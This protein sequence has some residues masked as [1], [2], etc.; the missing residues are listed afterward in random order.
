MLRGSLVVLLVAALTRDMTR[1]APS[2]TIIA[3]QSSLTTTS[4]TS[5]TR[6]TVPTKSNQ[7][8]QD[9]PSI[10][11]A[12]PQRLLDDKVT[13]QQQ[14][15]Q[16]EETTETVCVIPPGMRLATVRDPQ[17]NPLFDMVVVD[18]D[19]MGQHIATKGFWE[20]RQVQDVED[21]A[22]P[23]VINNNN[24]TSS[25][26]AANVAGGGAVFYDVGANIGYY[27]FLFAHAG[28][29]VVAF[30]PLPQNVAAYRATLCLHPEWATRITLVEQGLSDRTATCQLIGTTLASKAQ[31]LNGVVEV[32][33]P[34]ASSTEQP[35]PV[36]TPCAEQPGLAIC[37]TTVV[38]TLDAAVL[39][40]PNDGNAQARFPPPSIIKM[41]V[42]G[43]ELQ[44]LQ[45]ATELFRRTPPEL[46]QF[47]FKSA[48]Q[49]QVSDWLAAHGYE[50]GTKRG[51][52][53]NTV[54]RLVTRPTLAAA[55][56]V[57]KEPES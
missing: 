3:E 52:D 48:K 4:T 10:R 46:V 55:V 54:A 14:Q 42:E 32:R 24:N 19:F 29:S 20:I 41:D 25:N 35:P 21:L 37:Q 5:G 15:Q 38:T 8:H 6:A 36:L 9:T 50:V 40:D 56:A 49:S 45:G 39:R 31:Y 47:E 23:A 53:G 7:E 28:Y 11:A 22:P 43:H 44:V 51:H 1:S 30:E 18:G 57:A 27:S 13:Q 33:C 16:Q 26:S 34:P 2:T 17:G 12:S